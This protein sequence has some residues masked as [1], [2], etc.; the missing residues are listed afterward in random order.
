MEL[1]WA[2]RG[3]TPTSDLLRDASPDFNH[4]T[5]S[6]ILSQLP[7]IQRTPN[8]GKMDDRPSSNA[9][10]SPGE[11]LSPMEQEVIDEYVRLA[12]NMKKVPVNAKSHISSTTFKSLVRFATD[13]SALSPVAR[14]DD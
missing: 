2:D 14:L 12:D 4:T 3:P 5:S 6:S 10:L 1:N 7:A 13:S 9:L 8:K 11:E